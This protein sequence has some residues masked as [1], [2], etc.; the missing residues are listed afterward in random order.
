MPNREGIETIRDFCAEFPNVPII[1]MSGGGRLKRL[2]NL[3][4]AK[5]LGA[6]VIIR[7]PFTI[8]D[9]LR[10]VAVLLNGFEP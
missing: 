2:G 6:A 5:A 9:L 10:S 3:S 4:T 1:A 8:R 7:K